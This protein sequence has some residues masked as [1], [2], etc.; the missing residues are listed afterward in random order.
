L[1]DNFAR[2]IKCLGKLSVKN[3]QHPNYH[4]IVRGSDEGK[5]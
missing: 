4:A 3:P 2:E 1:I 5:E